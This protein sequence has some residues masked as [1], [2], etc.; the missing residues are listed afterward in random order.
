MPPG[1]FVSGVVELAVMLSTQRHHELVTGFQAE[2]SGLCKAEVMRVGG[3]LRA[4]EA[5]LQ[6]DK[7]EVLFVSHSPRLRVR[8]NALVDRS[9]GSS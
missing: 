1:E 2:P 4:G 8:K 9:H 3:S 5:R 7:T 6:R